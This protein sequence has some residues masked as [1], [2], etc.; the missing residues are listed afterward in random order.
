MK[1]CISDCH[2]VGVLQAPILGGVHLCLL[3]RYNTEL[4]SIENHQA[5]EV[6][7]HQDKVLAVLDKL[8]EP[9]LLGQ[10]WQLGPGEGV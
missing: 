5:V 6:R 7:V 9:G 4:C 8:G 3:T 1:L 2:D 10:I